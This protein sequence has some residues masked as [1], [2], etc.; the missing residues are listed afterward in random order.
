MAINRKISRI[1]GKKLRSK[2]S[3]KA[4]KSLAGHVL[5]KCRRKNKKR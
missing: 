5:S 3:D 1:A 2:K 4:T